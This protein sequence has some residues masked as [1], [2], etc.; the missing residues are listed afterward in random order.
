MSAERLGLLPYGGREIADLRGLGKRPKEMVLLSLIG[1]L[2]EANPVLVARPEK[3]YDWRFLVELEV[4]VVAETTTPRS[5]LRSLLAA[6]QALPTAYLGL[7][8]ADRQDGVNLAWGRFDTQGLPTFRRMAYFDRQRFAG[9][10]GREDCHAG[11]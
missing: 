8:L 5:A 4:M 11:A 9:L 1:P 10:G 7:W 2:R 3:A 6:L